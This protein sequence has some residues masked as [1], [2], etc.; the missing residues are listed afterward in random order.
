MIIRA[1]DAND[2]LAKANKCVSDEELYGDDFD[3]LIDWRYAQNCPTCIPPL[4]EVTLKDTRKRD[5]DEQGSA[6]ADADL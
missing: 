2:A 4:M 5:Y 1:T 3:C 6:F